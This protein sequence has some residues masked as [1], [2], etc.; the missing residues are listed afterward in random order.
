MP[1]T[2]WRQY[3]NGNVC[4]KEY[5]KLHSSLPIYFEREFGVFIA[6]ISNKQHFGVFVAHGIQREINLV[7]KIENGPRAYTSNR[8][9]EL[10]AFRCDYKLVIVVFVFFGQE[11]YFIDD[12]QAG[13]HFL[14]RVR[15]RNDLKVW[16]VHLGDFDQARHFVIVAEQ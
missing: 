4:K 13:A 12:G 7:G 11:L 16:R 2:K 8:Y 3:F 15:R 9:D 14:V 6:N 5:K 10:F 1:L